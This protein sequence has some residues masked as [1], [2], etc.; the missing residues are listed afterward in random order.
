MDSALGRLRMRH[1][2]MRVGMGTL[3]R[4]RSSSHLLA[5]RPRV[6]LVVVSL[7]ELLLP[8]TVP[9]W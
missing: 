9:R 1:H 6:L 2:R 5:T 4:R 7:G 3:P 8:R